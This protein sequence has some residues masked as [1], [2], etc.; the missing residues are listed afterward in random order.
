MIPLAGIRTVYE[1]ALKHHSIIKIQQNKRN[2]LKIMIIY[3]SWVVRK[4]NIGAIKGHM[5]T[6]YPGM[7]PVTEPTVEMIMDGIG[8]EQGPKGIRKWI[9]ILKRF[10]RD[11]LRL[12]AK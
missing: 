11:C 2:C 1:H 4:Y 6:L 3:P 8:L 9:L 10:I 7:D 5:V 12:K